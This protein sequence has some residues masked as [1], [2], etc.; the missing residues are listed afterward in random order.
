MKS[1]SIRF[2]PHA[3]KGCYHLRNHEKRELHSQPS[4][5]SFCVPAS[6]NYY[7]T[8]VDTPEKTNDTRLA[9]SSGFLNGKS[10]EKITGAINCMRQISP[11]KS[12]YS[13]PEKLWFK[14][15]LNFITLTLPIA[16]FHDDNTITRQCLRPFLDFMKYN[17]K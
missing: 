4:K 8:L 12:V 17:A 14:F 5:L 13:A 10:R 6:E 1:A 7:D 9:V 16:Q 15:R 3:I 11:M 2:L